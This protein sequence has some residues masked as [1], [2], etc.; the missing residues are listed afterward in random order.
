MNG[1]ILTG[2][3]YTASSIFNTSYYAW[4]AFDTHVDTGWLSLNGTFDTV[5]GEYKGS[6]LLGGITGVTTNS[7]SWN[8]IWIKIDIGQTVVLSE[9][10]IHPR[11]GTSHTPMSPRE[12][13]F[14]SSVD[15]INWYELHHL[16]LAEGATGQALSL[17][18]I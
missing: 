8:G 5:T 15:G 18:H 1:S 14:I 10:K 7:N 3:V 16:D 4:K 11:S 9:Y 2:Q 17:I 12:G 6:G 13:Y